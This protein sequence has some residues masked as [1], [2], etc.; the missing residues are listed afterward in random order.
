MSKIQRTVLVASICI[1]LYSYTMGA[2][3]LCE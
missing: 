1:T 3:L 2:N